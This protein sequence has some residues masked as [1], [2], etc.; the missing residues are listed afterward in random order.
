MKKRF[1]CQWSRAIVFSFTVAL[2]SAF[3]P[4]SSALAAQT[5]NVKTYGATGD[6]TT[7]D[8][9]AL[10][11]ALAAANASPGSTLF[12]PAGDYLYSSNLTADGIS[13][14]GQRATLSS[15]GSGVSLELTGNNVALQDM[16]FAIKGFGVGFAVHV[17]NA[18]RFIVVNNTFNSPFLASIKIS[19]SSNGEVRSNTSNGS[20]AAIAVDGS[21]Q[22]SIKNNN[23]TADG[24]NSKF[25]R[26]DESN[27][28]AIESNR[29]NGVGICVEE[30]DSTTTSCT[31]NVFSNYQTGYLGKNGKSLALTRN[32]FAA[33]STASAGVFLDGEENA[34]VSNNS[35][36]GAINAIKAEKSTGL[37]IKRNT[38]K[39]TGT[40][41]SAEEGSDLTVTENQISQCQN[42]AISGTYTK[43]TETISTNKIRDCGLSSSG[44][45]AVIYVFSPVASSIPITGN[46]YAGNAA[47]LQ[48]FIRCRQTEP[49]A[50]V[51]GNIT[52]TELPNLIGP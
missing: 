27:N 18:S 44:T 25:L 15:T 29:A 6:G 40:A 34:N 17:H 33:A 32:Q 47:N 3:F 4:S 30:L 12:F 5:F 41:I 37:S 36:Q 2:A 9:S 39:D 51:F 38:I 50:K 23:A 21:S 46:S 20:S 10:K 13:V 14:V 43:G 52:N 42:G 7:D 48:Y 8:T 22:I 35:M 31:D 1:N 19:K 24:G 45:Q 26:L 16:A 28:T 49:P 11:A